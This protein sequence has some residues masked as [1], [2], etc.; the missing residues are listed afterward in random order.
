MLGAFAEL[1]SYQHDDLDRCRRRH[2][3]DVVDVG[4]LC[5]IMRQ[6]NASYQLLS[7]VLDC[8]VCQTGA[9]P[10]VANLNMF[11]NPY[12]INHARNTSRRSSSSNSSSITIAK[13]PVLNRCCPP[14]QTSPPAYYL[15]F[16]VRLLRACHPA[17][18]RDGI[19]DL[20]SGPHSS[21]GLFDEYDVLE[22]VS[23]SRESRYLSNHTQQFS[24]PVKTINSFGQFLNPTIPFPLL[25]WT[26]SPARLH[27]MRGA[28]LPGVWRS[29][30]LIIYYGK[31]I[32]Y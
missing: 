21:R 18:V 16:N 20:K 8:C 3:V 26:H 5:C 1:A 29:L 27:F 31:H 6:P 25:F 11:M 12:H 13:R 14:E 9:K 7:H 24:K 32:K 23:K 30:T 4:T 15:L 28:I 10:C 17:T 2:V 19:V 22:N